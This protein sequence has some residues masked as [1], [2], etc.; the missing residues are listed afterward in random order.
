M[1]MFARDVL[2]QRRRLP[3][4]QARGLKWPGAEAMSN[5]T[6]FFAGELTREFLLTSSLMA[7]SVTLLPKSRKP[8]MKKFL[9][10][11]CVAVLLVLGVM[12]WR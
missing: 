2:T 4:G 12:A 6:K 5:K 1:P 9:V 3:A 8:Q 10:P 11:F 7:S